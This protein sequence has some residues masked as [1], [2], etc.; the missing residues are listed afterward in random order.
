MTKKSNNGQRKNARSNHKSTDPEMTKGE[1]REIH[2][3]GR[4]NIPRLT[5]QQ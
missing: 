3:I 2:Q 4:G 1:S 5:T